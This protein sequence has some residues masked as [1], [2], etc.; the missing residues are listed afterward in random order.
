MD[1]VTELRPGTTL[2]TKDDAPPELP[3][4]MESD[5]PPNSGDPETAIQI[6]CSH[7]VSTVSVAVWHPIRAHRTA[8]VRYARGNGGQRAA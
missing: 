6:E 7:L 8:R 5:P 4:A 1:N 3:Q 2:P